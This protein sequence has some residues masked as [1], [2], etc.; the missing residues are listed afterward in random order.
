MNEIT[1]RTVWEVDG[2]Q[3][4]SEAEATAHVATKRATEQLAEMI[5]ANSNFSR[6]DSADVAEAIVANW[7]A[8]KAIMK[9]CA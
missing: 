6:G 8:I 5:F 1:T 9:E 2:R 7:T 4:D 3:F